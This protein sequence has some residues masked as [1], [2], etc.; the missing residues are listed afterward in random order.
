MP[1]II[2]N[3][4]CSARKMTQLCTFYK[5]FCCIM[6]K[7]CFSNE[8]NRKKLKNK[9]KLLRGNCRVVKELCSAKWAFRKAEESQSHTRD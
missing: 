1:H 9:I 4:T 3:N 5:P 7:R 6:F 8:L 2:S